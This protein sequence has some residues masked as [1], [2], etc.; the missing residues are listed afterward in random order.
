MTEA[1][2]TDR[3]LAVVGDTEITPDGRPIFGPPMPKDETKGKETSTDQLP[4]PVKNG[5]TPSSTEAAAGPP[6]HPELGGSG[7]RASN[8]NPSPLLA[9]L[10]AQ[11]WRDRLANF[12][13]LH[14]GSVAVTDLNPPMALL[15][16]C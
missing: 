8:S 7:Y 15:K 2:Q 14:L 16:V 6:D 11:E 12:Q 5:Q 1:D 4:F 13:G 10:S 3:D 9:E